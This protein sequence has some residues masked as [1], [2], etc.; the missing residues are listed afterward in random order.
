MWTFCLFFENPFVCL[1]TVSIVPPAE[2]IL[3]EDRVDRHC[4]GILQALAD[5]R[6]DFDN[7]QE[8]RRKLNEGFRAKIH[9]K[10]DTLYTATKSYT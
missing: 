2:L 7:L 1:W 10:E 9:S 5:L 3:H 4:K 6:T 8:T